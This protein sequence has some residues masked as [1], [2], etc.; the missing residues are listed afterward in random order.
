MG[1]DDVPLTHGP[2]HMSGPIPWTFAHAPGVAPHG[3]RLG[4][5]LT[6]PWYPKV[7]PEPLA[8]EH[9]PVSKGQPWSLTG[10]IGISI[11]SSALQKNNSG[12]P[13]LGY[14]AMEGKV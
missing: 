1:G 9:I 11:E 10:L 3:L 6:G 8:S 14:L 7:H 2:M 12:M 5:L 4:D 13:A